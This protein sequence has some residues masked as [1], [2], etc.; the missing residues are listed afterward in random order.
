[1]SEVDNPYSIS[2][3]ARRFL[4]FHVGYLSGRDSDNPAIS[5]FKHHSI[6]ATVN[7]L[8]VHT[9]LSLR[10]TAPTSAS[11]SSTINAMPCPIVWRRLCAQALPVQTNY[12]GYIA[13]VMGYR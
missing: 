2:L 5:R 1:M 7:L 3:V 4:P 9:A 6:S 12:Y 10:S 13:C 11:R 8:V